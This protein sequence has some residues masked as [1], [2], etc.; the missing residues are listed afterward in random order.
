MVLAQSD[1]VESVR[2]HLQRKGYSVSS[3]VG[4]NEVSVEMTAVR[5][6]DHFVIEA[7]WESEQPTDKNIIFALGKLVKRM[8][9]TGSWYHY[10]LALPKDYFRFLREFELAGVE[11]LGLHLFLVESFYTLTELDH[12]ET[13]ELIK[14]LKAG[15]LSQLN[16]WGINYY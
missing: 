15:N 8:N 7:M 12:K 2:E 13:V 9:E 14:A 16:L 10:A 1:V 6:Q 4:K 5:D 11:L 3:S